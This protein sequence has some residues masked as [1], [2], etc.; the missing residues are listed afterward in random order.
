MRK[1]S[2]LLN[3]VLQENAHDTW[4]WLL[5]PS[6]GYT[7]REAYHFLTNNGNPVY[8]SMVDDVWHK[9]IPSKM[10]GIKLLFRHL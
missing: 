7:V 4:R 2:T 10:Y 1:C 6:H 5:H 8:R 9:Y 3:I